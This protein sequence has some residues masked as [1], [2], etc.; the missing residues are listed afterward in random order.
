M[1]GPWSWMAAAALALA[2]AGCGDPQVGAGPEPLP[3]PGD[4]I[5]GLTAGTWTWVDVPDSACDDGSPTGIG[6]NPGT[7]PDLVVVMNGGGACWDYLTCY[8]LNTAIH[9]PFGEPELRA[10]EARDL[11]GSILD[12]GL[13]G[14]PFQDATLVFVPYCTGDTH[15]GDNVAAYLGPGDS[16]TYHHVGHA[17]IVAFVKRLAATWPSPRKLV[18]SG[19]SA[20]G[21]GSVVNY[22]TFRRAWPGAETYLVDDSGPPLERGAIP[23]GLLNAWYESWRLDLALDPICGEACRTDHSAG[24][25]AVLAKYPADRIALLSSLQ[26]QVIAGYFVLSGPQLEQELRRLAADVLDPAPNA[27]YFFVPGS[28][29]TMLKTPAAFSQGVPLLTWLGQ[30]VSGDPAW[31]SRQP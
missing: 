5:V 10:L 12:R 20:G 28:S 26:D 6:V 24:L 14:N 1:A 13:P 9:G 31:I 25:A 17:N 18:V 23:Q 7:G 3:P 30:Q 11:P 8:V 19:G 22:D 21:F 15:G 4:P 29:H 2:L 27:R 16:R